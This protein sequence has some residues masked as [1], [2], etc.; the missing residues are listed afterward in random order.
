MTWAAETGAEPDRA[1]AAIEFLKN[2]TAR[3][4]TEFQLLDTGILDTHDSVT[5]QPTNT[6]I[7]RSI[8]I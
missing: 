3:I 2:D 7:S 8:P 5:P 6:M 4:A 1:R